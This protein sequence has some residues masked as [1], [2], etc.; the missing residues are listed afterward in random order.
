MGVEWVPQLVRLLARSG[1]RAFEVMGT[2]G[3]AVAVAVASLI[4]PAILAFVRKAGTIG[5]RAA[6]GEWKATLKLGG[7]ITLALWVCVFL[8]A[9]AN[10]IYTDHTGLVGENL[11][12]SDEI[13]RLEKRGK[14]LEAE[15]QTLKERP[16]GVVVKEPEDHCWM[17]WMATF[18]NRSIVRAKSAGYT[19]LQCNKRI[20]PPFEVVVLFDRNPLEVT[21]LI[22]GAPA[23]MGGSDSVQGRV[24]RKQISSPPLLAHQLVVV[25]AHG[26]DEASAPHP[27]QGVLRP[28]R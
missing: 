9:M 18:P 28:L 14:T 22:L 8:W 26:E 15:V 17:T 20:D 27:L 19:I 12:K 6:L 1:Q 13:T 16:I 4:V 10:V 24:F 7:Q 25:L 23:V 21:S 5:F 3:L 11:K 2:T